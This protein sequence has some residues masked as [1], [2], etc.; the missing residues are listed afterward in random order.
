MKKRDGLYIEL[1]ER[2]R[3]IINELKIRHAV[4]ISQLIKNLIEEYYLKLKQATRD[5]E[6]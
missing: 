3:K 2:E 1:S 4:N 6:K 5:G